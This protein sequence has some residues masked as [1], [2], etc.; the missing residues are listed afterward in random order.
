[1]SDKKKMTLFFS[2]DIMKC[3]AA[4]ETLDEDILEKNIFYPL[5]GRFCYI[6]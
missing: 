2:C 3:Y 1:M 5:P 6:L 4:R